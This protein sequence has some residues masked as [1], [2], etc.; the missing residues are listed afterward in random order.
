[1]NRFI[2]ANAALLAFL[3]GSLR[4]APAV[5]V[6]SDGKRLDSLKVAG[7]ELLAANKEVHVFDRSD[8]GYRPV[9]FTAS[10][11]PAADKSSV[12]FT[13]HLTMPRDRSYTV[14]RLQVDLPPLA[15]GPLKDSDRWPEI[16]A[17]LMQED[18]LPALFR[19]RVEV[20]QVTPEPTVIDITEFGLKRIVVPIVA[21][22]MGRGFFS[23]ITERNNFDGLDMQYTRHGAA[24]CA[25]EM[26]KEKAIR[27]AQ[28][29]TRT[30]DTQAVAVLTAL[31]IAEELFTERRQA[32][33]LRRKIREKSQS[34]LDC[35][36]REARV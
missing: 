34:L 25:I 13:L 5:T 18:P 23:M 22:R 15:V 20:A 32:G 27:E 8:Q 16:E 29:H 17:A 11:T 30:P 7:T 19:N 21:N 6:Q 31:Q 3:A 4:A 10:I 9:P 36:A 14:S 35:L 26:A 2:L 33:E 1:M 28:K 24:V 12:E